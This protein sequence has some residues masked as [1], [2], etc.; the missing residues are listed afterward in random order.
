[1]VTKRRKKKRIRIRI[2]KGNTGEGVKAA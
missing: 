1:M 2:R